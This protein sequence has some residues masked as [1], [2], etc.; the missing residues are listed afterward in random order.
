[1]SHP[2]RL[3]NQHSAFSMEEPR[4]SARL[5][6]MVR[7]VV[8]GREYEAEQPL[9]PCPH[10]A[11]GPSPRSTTADEAR[12]GTRAFGHN[13]RFAR[14]K[15]PTTGSIVAGYTLQ[16]R[17]GDGA[18]SAV[19]RAL[20]DKGTP[21]AVKVLSGNQSGDHEA[22]ERFNR[23]ARLARRIKHP[24]LVRVHESGQDEKSGA[25]Y[26]V[27]DLVEG[28]TL[29][30][31][32]GRNQRIP[33]R[34]ALELMYQITQAVALLHKHGCVHR[35]IKP[36][37][38]LIA[39]GVAKLTDL[40]FVKPS[41]EV[42]N[43]RDLLIM[44]TPAYMAP[45]QAVDAREATPASD[46][47]AIG[48]TLYHA[49]TGQPPFSSADGVDIMGRIL[50]EIPPSPAELVDQ[51]PPSVDMLVCWAMRKDPQ[52][53]PA[54]ASTLCQAMQRILSNPSNAL[55]IARA[56][57]LSAFSSETWPVV[58]AI[59]IFVVVVAVFCYFA[60]HAKR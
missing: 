20:D 19:Y 36:S 13:L 30:T 26:L 10:C 12:G 48:A 33:W 9:D 29:A 4:S 15:D 42:P 34:S 6:A 41:S 18:T 45:E 43:D 32:I 49:L 28:E 39:D 8:C 2:L 7:C 57:R 25:H 27:M 24:N 58:A 11:P 38:I 44:G 37:N 51:L 52:T 59:I 3:R 55:G 50:R 16:E 46:V 35:D 22:L 23:E 17:V 31:L 54:D 14:P 53:R 21:L 60:F 5:K 40:G 47:Y 1:M 56:R